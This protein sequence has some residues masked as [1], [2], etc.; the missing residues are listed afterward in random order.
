MEGSWLPFLVYL[1]HFWLL[2]FFRWLMLSPLIADRIPH[3]VYTPTPFTSLHSTNNLVLPSPSNNSFLDSSSRSLGTSQMIVSAQEAAPQLR[4]HQS[5]RSLSPIPVKSSSRSDFSSSSSNLFLQTSADKNNSAM[6][7]PFSNR[8]QDV[9]S[10]SESSGDYENLSLIP[11]SI[12]FERKSDRPSSPISS[13]PV[14]RSLFAM[15]DNSEV[16]NETS[17]TPYTEDQEQP[18]L[19]RSTAHRHSS[20]PWDPDVSE[21]DLSFSQHDY[22]NQNGNDQSKFESHSSE[23]NRNSF[24]VGAPRPTDF[25]N[26]DFHDNLDMLGSEPDSSTHTSRS[27][28]PSQSPPARCVAFYIFFFTLVSQLRVIFFY[29]YEVFSIRFQS[30]FI[31]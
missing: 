23:W 18:S 21:S 14:A 19:S 28:L 12:D 25:E 4:S 20:S 8:L 5:K 6:K 1:F 22:I 2:L 11:T 15:G 7:I 29:F 17:D 13:R 24:F 31:F 9:E 27:Q 30:I 10:F 16:L 3:S 26:T